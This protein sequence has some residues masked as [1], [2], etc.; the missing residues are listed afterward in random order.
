MS[1]ASVLTF[2]SAGDCLTTNSLS[3]SKLYYDRRPI[4][5]F[6]SVS[7]PH[8]VPKTGFLLSTDICR[9]F[10]VGAHSLM[11]GRVCRLQLLLVLASTVI[12]VSESSETHDHILLSQIRDSPNLEVRSSYLY[13]PGTW[14]PSYTTRLDTEFHFRLLIQLAV[15]QWR[16]SNPPP[17][18]S[19]A[20]ICPAYIIS[21]RTTQTKTV[22]LLLFS[23]VVVQTCLFAMPLISNDSCIFAYLAVVNQQ[24]VYM[25][26]YV[27]I[28]TVLMFTNVI[29]KVLLSHLVAHGSS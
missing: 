7:I 21:A 5:Q 13:P 17:R 14:W 18:K 26:Q 15:L 9:F 1:S 19:I 20:P 12:L 22:P 24:R 11:G 6:N 4:G 3:M 8:L 25:P 29:A 23:I 27:L 2:L 28:H 10:D 16:Y